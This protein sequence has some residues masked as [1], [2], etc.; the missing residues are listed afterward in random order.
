MSDGSARA[1]ELAS[2]LEA[3]ADALVA[4]VSALPPELVTWK[5]APDV[6]SVMEILCHVAEFVPYWTGQTLAIVRTPDVE[7]GR[8]HGDSARLAAVERAADRSLLDVVDAIQ[9][10]ARAAAAQIRGLDDAALDTEAVSGNPRWGR[11][12]AAFVIEH[13]L[14][15]HVDKHL[16]Q[17]Q[18]NMAQYEVRAR[19]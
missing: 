18:R 4:E 14:V 12:P 11:Q 5:P 9:N 10:G 6:W 8:T 7:W 17:V 1:H 2:R 3:T 16:G 13:L 19:T 15:Q